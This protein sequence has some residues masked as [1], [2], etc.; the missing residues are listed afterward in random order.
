MMIRG[1]R[2]PVVSEHKKGVIQAGRNLRVE[3][4]RFLVCKE[5]GLEKAAV[6]ADMTKSGEELR[7]A[8]AAGGQGEQSLKSMQAAPL[9]HLKV[10]VEMVGQREIRTEFERFLESLI[11]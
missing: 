10:R 9:V 8:M 7:I 3:A 4:A 6:T 1:Q 2:A 11:G 5:R